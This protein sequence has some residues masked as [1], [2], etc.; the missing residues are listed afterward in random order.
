MS[1][2]ALKPGDLTVTCAVVNGQRVLRVFRPRAAVLTTECFRTLRLA[3]DASGICDPEEETQVVNRTHTRTLFE[4]VRVPLR[5]DIPDEVAMAHSE[6]VAD[7]AF[8]LWKQEARKAGLAEDKE[9]TYR[10][11]VPT[12]TAGSVGAHA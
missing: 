6:K 3:Y 8:D 12:R 7:D 2:Q 11:H 10:L 4:L 1:R 9:I 5:D